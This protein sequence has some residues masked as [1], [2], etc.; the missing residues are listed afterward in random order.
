MGFRR[1]LLFLFSITLGESFLKKASRN[2]AL[3][4]REVIS[5]ARPAVLRLEQDQSATNIQP[6][7]NARGFDRRNSQRNAVDANK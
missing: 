3:A 2:P 1:T 6:T 5:N 7:E 4:L